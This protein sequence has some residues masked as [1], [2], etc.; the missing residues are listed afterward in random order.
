MTLSLIHLINASLLRAASQLPYVAIY[1]YICICICIYVCGVAR[2]G[3]IK[4]DFE[5]IMNPERGSHDGKRPV[6]EV[7]LVS[8]DCL[9]ESTMYSPVFS[10]KH[11]S[12]RKRLL[13]KEALL[14]QTSER[15][16]NSFPFLWCRKTA[17]SGTLRSHA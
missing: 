9:Q 8:K 3:W 1:I 15:Q 16:L 17:T 5:K 12:K 11:S 4:A 13:L 6:R 14:L 7:L 2:E 10:N